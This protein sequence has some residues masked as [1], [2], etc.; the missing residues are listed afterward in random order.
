MTPGFGVRLQT[1]EDAV[2]TIRADLTAHR[3]EFAAF[4][5]DPSPTNALFAMWCP[6]PTG[7]VKCNFDASFCQQSLQGGGRAIFQD[8]R[9]EV[10]HAVIF[11]PFHAASPLEAEALVCQRAILCAFQLGFSC[12]WFESDAKVVVNGVLSG[13]HCPSEIA[14]L[15]YDIQLDLRRFSSATLTHVRRSSN[16]VAHAL[17]ALSKLG[18]ESNQMLTSLPPSVIPFVVADVRS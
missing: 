16:M 15:C 3:A 10:L 1:L 14:S 17:V 5:T 18:L 12:L 13:V 4:H 11:C 6:P 8:F 2:V 9:G 7:I